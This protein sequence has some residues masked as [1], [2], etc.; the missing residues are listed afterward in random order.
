MTALY[1]RIAAYGLAALLAG[2]IG[3]FVN[4]DRWEAKYES[5][6]AGHAQEL[7]DAQGKAKQAL[8][9]QLEQFQETSTNNAKVIDA[10][11]T[12]TLQAQA[13]GARDHDLAQRLLHAAQG[14]AGSPGVPQTGHQP[15]TPPAGDP[16]G[17]ERLGDLVVAAADESRAC[18][19]QLNALLEELQPQL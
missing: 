14:S 16:Q 17:T 9:T 19:R 6:Q 11:N 2:S 5:L 12:Q 18:A 13:D 3:W 15:A 7:A 4:G 1:L 10:L 8:Q